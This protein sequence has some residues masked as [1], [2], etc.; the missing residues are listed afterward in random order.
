MTLPTPDHLE[1]WRP[2]P[3]DDLGIASNRLEA[4]A[5]RALALEGWRLRSHP[6]GVIVNAPALATWAECSDVAVDAVRVLEAHGWHVPTLFDED[7]APVP[8]HGPMV[9]GSPGVPQHHVNVLAFQAQ[10]QLAIHAR[11]AAWAPVM[12]RLEAVL[13]VYVAATAA[14]GARIRTAYDHRRRA[15]RRARRRGRR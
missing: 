12:R 5:F 1:Q 4:G 8:W 10:T 2:R 3:L 6:D 7:G 9:L 13:D 15:R 11:L 14:E